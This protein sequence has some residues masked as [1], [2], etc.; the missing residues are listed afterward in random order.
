M[1][2]AP[3]KTNKLTMK[4]NKMLTLAALVAGSLF[5]GS[6]ALQ[7]QDN[8]NTPPPGAPPGGMR[9]R[10]L[11]FEAIAKN[12]ELTDDQKPKAKPVIDEMLQKQ[13]DLRAD[14]SV[15]QADKRAKA[16]E[17][18][19]AATTKLKE[20]LTADQLAKWEKMGQRQR[21]PAPPAG[22][23]DAAAPKN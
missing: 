15:A 7:A 22:G 17:I 5:A 6:V 14:T 9:G 19:E 20:I 11:N 3:D 21:P 12:L 4:L 8:T 1:A 10:A 18:R 23:G 2:G 16:K 13:R